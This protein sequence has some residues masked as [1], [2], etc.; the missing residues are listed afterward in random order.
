[1]QDS[2]NKQP[3]MLEDAM[4]GKSRDTKHQSKF[5][6]DFENRNFGAFIHEF[7][8]AKKSSMEDDADDY[9][10][11]VLGKKQSSSTTKHVN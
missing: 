7:M 9:S 11:P 3:S 4:T 1:M 10:S 5:S 6:H 2:F 8:F